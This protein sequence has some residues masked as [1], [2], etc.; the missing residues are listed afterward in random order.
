MTDVKPFTPAQARATK[1]GNIPPKMIEAVNQL[2]AENLQ[3]DQGKVRAVV[4]QRDIVA[5]YKQLSGVASDQEVY[6]SG[7]LD[8]EPIF[9]DAGWKVSYDKPA[10]CEDYP[11]TFTFTEK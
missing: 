4:K 7:W 1:L 8:F 9:R 10:Y 11:A 5:R 3:G 6:D 2:I